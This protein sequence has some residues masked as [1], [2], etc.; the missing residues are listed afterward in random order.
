MY[1]YN[2]TTKVWDPY[3]ATDIIAWG[4]GT[5][6]YLRVMTNNYMRRPLFRIEAETGSAIK[7]H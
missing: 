4:S 5:S 6:Y 3:N 1:N 7:A 2:E